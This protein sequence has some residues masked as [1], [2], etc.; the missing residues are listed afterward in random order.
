ML[1]IGKTKAEVLSSGGRTL[2]HV[3]AHEVT[4]D[5]LESHFDKEIVADQRSGRRRP[6]RAELGFGDANRAG[7]RTGVEGTNN[8]LPCGHEESPDFAGGI[9]C[10]ALPN[11]ARAAV[12]DR[13]TA[14][15]GDRVFGVVLDGEHAVLR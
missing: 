7:C 1:E 14:A 10:R 4:G 12:K 3:P 9:A 2:Q 5:D 8:A 11:A 6:S 13:Q 15:G